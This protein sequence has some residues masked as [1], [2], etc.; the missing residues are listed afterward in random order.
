VGQLVTC[1]CVSPE[2][3]RQL[4]KELAPLV[5]AE[6]QG[7][8]GHVTVDDG[9]M[10]TKQAAEYL[11]TTANALHKLTASRAI[12][13]EQAGPGCKCLYKRSDLDAWVKSGAASSLFPEG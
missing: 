2:S 6:L 4:A 3:L 13:F 8:L 10:T 11:G 5:A 9:W 7:D 1:S 12:P